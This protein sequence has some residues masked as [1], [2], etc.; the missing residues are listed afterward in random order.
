MTFKYF[1]AFSGIGGFDEG[2]RRVL[3]DAECIG[4]SEIDKFA[5]NIYEQHFPNRTNYGDIKEINEKEIPDFDLFCGGFPCPSFSIAG[6]RK[7]LNDCGRG[8][9]FWEIV[10]ICR[11]KQPAYIFLENVEGLLS[12][13][14][15]K[16]IYDFDIMMEK[17]CEIGYVIDFALLN[18]KYFGVPQNRSRIFILAKRVD[19]VL[20]ELI[21]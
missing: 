15:T 5:V 17:L 16:G 3:S 2:I 18:S 13:Q 14:T 7:G 9:L 10:R 12:S 8:D 1:S 4:Y 19:L 21:I 20:K 6:K 11:K